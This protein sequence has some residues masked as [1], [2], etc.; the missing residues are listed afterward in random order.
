[1]Y[2]TT[3]GEKIVEEGELATWVSQSGEILDEGDLHLG[4]RN[5]HTGVPRELVL[6]FQEGNLWSLSLDRWISAVNGVVKSDC[7]SER[8]R[9]KANT[10]HVVHLVFG[11]CLKA[12]GH[13]C[14]MA[15]SKTLSVAIG[16]SI[17]ITVNVTI[18]VAIRVSIAVA[19]GVAIGISIE[20]IVVM[21][22]DGASRRV[23]KFGVR[24]HFENVDRLSF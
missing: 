7:D 10:D 19:V 8:R 5:L 15:I 23:W 12:R 16:V 3:N 1:M 9:S 22:I 18:G 11:N 6:T 14:W 17:R 13:M 21:L 20:N 4:A 2:Q 24:R